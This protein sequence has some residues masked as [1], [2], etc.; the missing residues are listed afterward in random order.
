MYPKI[1]IIIPAYLPTEEYIYFLDKC[2]DSIKQQTYKNIEITI[3]Y[4]GPI[5]KHY[6]DCN[7]VNLK[8]KTSAAIARNVGASISNN[9]NYFC[10]LDADDFFV[11][12]KIE[13][14]LEICLKENIDFCFTEPININKDGSERQETYSYKNISSHD[15]IKSKLSEVNFLPLSSCMIKS[16]SFFSCGMFPASIEYQIRHAYGHLNSKNTTCE[17]YLLWVTAIEKNCIFKKLK[18]QL[19]YCRVGSSVER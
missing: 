9:C 17:D 15:E 14:Q 11:V 8:T 16:E 5:N 3:V 18:E 6:E 12:N 2:V 1:G 13:K 4:N 10:F 7:I 19:T